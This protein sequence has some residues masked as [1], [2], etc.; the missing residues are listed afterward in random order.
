LT[1]TNNK[2]DGQHLAAVQLLANRRRPRTITAFPQWIEA[3]LKRA[4]EEAKK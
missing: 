2:L 1:A 4:V 3:A